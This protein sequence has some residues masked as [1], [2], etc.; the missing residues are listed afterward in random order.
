MPVV[1]P[2]PRLILLMGVAGTGKTTLGAQLAQDLAYDFIDADNFHSK[3]AVALMR[4][5]LPLPEELRDAWVERLHAELAARYRQGVNCVLAFS[6]LRA[7][8][9][10]RLMHTGYATTAFML[11][12]S[13]EELARRLAGRHLHFMPATQ[14]PDQLA[15]MQPLQADERIE[16]VDI[17]IATSAESLLALLSAG[18]K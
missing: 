15:S 7:R 14:L 9:R 10:R 12:G 16:P 5:G 8:H 17:G 13:R 4:S 1:D 2:G 6:G 18:L 3:E 11:H